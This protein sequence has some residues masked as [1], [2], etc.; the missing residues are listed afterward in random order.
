MSLSEVG[1]MDMRYG[2][3]DR[4]AADIERLSFLRNSFLLLLL[5]VIWAVSWPI[6][7]IGVGEVPPIW[8][9]FFRYLIATFLVFFLLAITGAFKV[10]PRADWSL[11]V[12]SGALQMGAYGALMGVALVALPPGRASVIA[13]STPIWVVPLAAWWLAE[14]TPALA[15]VGVIIGIAGVLTVAAPSLALDD[16]A[17]L[18]A[19]ICLLGASAAWAMSI[20]FVRGHRFTD[21]AF[22]L[23]PWQMLFAAVLLFPCAL[24][25]EGPPPAVSRTAAWSLA[26]VGPIST[27]FAY[28]AVVE[29]GRYFPA[30]T[31]SVALLATPS[32]GILISAQTLGE[33]VDTL[34]IA[35]VALVASG[36]WITTR[37]NQLP[38]TSADA[39]LRSRP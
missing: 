35:G 6:I 2:A 23:A 34:L 11:I 10:P 12:V 26:F 33:K 20:V 15:L 3:H 38:K 14:R 37:A 22:A 29:V 13:Y 7:K 5:I 4:T 31:M 21:S 19:Y 36:I 1:A 25:L 24:L 9:G 8:F 32:L 39:D 30:T 28:W 18:F 16:A 17:H 27:G